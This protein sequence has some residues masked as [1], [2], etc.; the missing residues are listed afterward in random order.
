M[1]LRAGRAGR[2]REAEGGAQQR[3]AGGAGEAL[4][5]NPGLG[6]RSSSD[7]IERLGGGNQ[8]TWLCGQEVSA[9]SGRPFVRKPVGSRVLAGYTHFFGCF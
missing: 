8:K 7:C 3:V 4:R 5:A 9:G 1:R 6:L 2:F